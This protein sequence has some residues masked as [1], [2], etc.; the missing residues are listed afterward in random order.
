MVVR[1]ED[2]FVKHKLEPVMF[3][4]SAELALE[5]NKRTWL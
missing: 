3:V 2:G 4:P 5:N 1:E